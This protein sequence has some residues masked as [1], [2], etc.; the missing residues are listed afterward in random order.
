MAIFLA[1]NEAFAGLDG[2]GIADAEDNCPNVV[3]IDQLDTDSDGFGDECDLDDDQDGF[4][5]LDDAYPLDP[6]RFASISDE[7]FQYDLLSGGTAAVTSYLDTSSTVVIP[8]EIDFD[9][10]KYFV[11]IAGADSFFGKG[12]TSV[13]FPRFLNQIQSGAF[14]SNPITS[15]NFPN[16]LRE[17]G[18]R[19]F[20]NNRLRTISINTNLVRK[21]GEQ[22]FY[23]NDLV[24]VVF[25]GDLPAFLAA[26]AFSGNP[27]SKVYFCFP[28]NAWEKENIAGL[29]PIM[30]CDRDGVLD[31]EDSFPKDPLETADTDGDGVG[32]NADEDD[33][34]D[35]VADS[36]DAFL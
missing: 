27:L 23:S 5:D 12:L 25:T 16:G 24:E 33:D 15:L 6:A 22:A 31:K 7:H 8:D 2:D 35:S 30:D 4:D 14:Y 18:P 17:I 11:S 3:N 36:A 26:D 13:T 29:T 28:Y 34:D 20:Y 19:A 9:Q 32:N 21:I 1:A 10:E